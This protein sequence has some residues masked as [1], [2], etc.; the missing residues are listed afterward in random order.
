M[1]IQNYINLIGSK[2]TFLDKSVYPHTK[3]TGIFQGIA[4]LSRDLK[5]LE[6]YVD[7]VTYSLSETE[8]I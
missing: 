4:L 6:F 1:A 3:C 8:F 7:Y 5:D 2:V